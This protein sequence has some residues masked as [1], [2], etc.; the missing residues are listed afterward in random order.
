MIKSELFASAG[1]DARC[2]GAALS[3][4]LCVRCVAILQPHAHLIRLFESAPAVI[5]YQSSL[6]PRRVRS[7]DQEPYI[8][9]MP[10]SEYP[11]GSS[12]LCEVSQPVYIKGEKAFPRQALRPEQWI[13]L[14]T[15]RWPSKDENRCLAFHHD[16]VD[17]EFHACMQAAVERARTEREHDVPSV[18]GHWHGVSVGVHE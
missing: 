12:C 15:E 10:H 17:Q 4:L 18:R 7:N 1:S 14:P 13:L 5:G 2:I 6:Q 9:T 16:S 8:R 3:V 11:S